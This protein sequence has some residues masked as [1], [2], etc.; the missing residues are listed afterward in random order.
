M[1]SKSQYNPFPLAR[2]HQPALVMP[3]KLIVTNTE[4]DLP[5]REA[6]YNQSEI[7]IG[8]DDSNLLALPDLKRVISREHAN[9]RMQGEAW[10][11]TDLGS[12]NFT[13]LNGVR[14]KPKEPHE[15]HTADLIRIGTFEIQFTIVAPAA[16]KPDYDR[17]IFLVNPFKEHVARLNLVL[18]GLA[19]QYRQEQG[20]RGDEA[21]RD[22]LLQEMDP[23]QGSETLSLLTN[24]LG[25]HTA[26]DPEL[27]REQEQ[28]PPPPALPPTPLP[29]PLMPQASPGLPATYVQVQQRAPAPSPPATGRT[30]AS[31]RILAAL[32][33][34][35]SKLA[36]APDQFRHEFIGQTIMALPEAS[37]MATKDLT[38]LQAQLFDPL[39]AQ[40]G[41][42]QRAAL[43]MEEA[44][45]LALHL[46][47][48]LDG[49]KASALKG[50]ELLL[51]RLDPDK[52]EAAVREK[53][54]LYR[55]IPLFA[56]AEVVRQL[57]QTARELRGEDW[58]AA[59]RRV[60][61]PAFVSAYLARASAARHSGDNTN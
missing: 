59:E 57:Q 23:D 46:V 16:A 14:L 45:K 30:A 56:H 25:I 2:I 43:I 44:D 29:S 53:R 36:S 18:K 49:Y 22:A 31:D 32:V 55:L 61:R 17:T 28:T 58:A 39:L 52:V 20:G 24:L 27:G 60:F 3:V 15:L 9:I 10:Y 50:A 37:F 33:Y 1:V 13:Y 5:L 7:S 26:G 6:L 4:E 41:V 11:L 40:E 34:F 47:A 48:F 54:A 12:H 42:E 19:N 8:R 38:R 51:D 21:L 35:F